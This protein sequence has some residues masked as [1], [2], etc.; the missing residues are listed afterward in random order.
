[1]RSAKHLKSILAGICAAA[2]FISAI[3]S[4]SIKAD[5]PSD[6]ST[7]VIENEK[8]S[9][10]FDAKMTANDDR[11]AGKTNI[12]VETFYLG[13]SFATSQWYS[14]DDVNS[15]NN[16]K[17]SAEAKDGYEIQQINY[18]S[19]QNGQNVSYKVECDKNTK[20]Y[21]PYYISDGSHIEV[22]VGDKTPVIDPA[23]DGYQ[24]FRADL[25]DYNTSAI[26]QIDDS[27]AGAKDNGLKFWRGGTSGVWYNNYSGNRVNGAGNY[28]SQGIVAATRKNGEPKFNVGTVPSIFTVGSDSYNGVT[29]KQSYGGVTFPFKY[30]KTSGMYSFDSDN[31]YASFD[32]TKVNVTDGNN[33]DVKFS[34]FNNDTYRN[35]TLWQRVNQNW[36]EFNNYDSKFS[37]GMKFG[38][39]FSLPKYGTVDGTE[40]GKPIVFDF[41]GDDDVWV[42]IDDQLVLDLGGIHGEAK[43]N[44]NF[45]TG[46]SYVQ[47]TIDQNN[48]CNENVYTDFYKEGFD[49]STLAGKEHT[50]TVY[51]FE[52]G[53]GQSNCKI[54]FNLPVI[55]KEDTPT[56]VSFRKVDTADTTKA[57]AGAK[58]TL[59]ST[60]GTVVAVGADGNAE[61]TSDASGMVNFK[62]VVQGTYTLTETKA[63]DGYDIPNPNTW[64]VIVTPDGKG[65]SSY[66]ITQT[67]F[68]NGSYVIK[69]TKQEVVPT[70][71]KTAEVT[72]YNNRTYKLTLNASAPVDKTT[73]VTGTNADVALIIDNSG[74]M[75]YTDA[76]IV[77]ETDSQGAFGKL[78]NLDTGKIYFTG[79]ISGYDGTKIDNEN[80]QDR[81]MSTARYDNTYYN[82][83]KG[84]KY[85]F[86][87]GDSWY[88][89]PISDINKSYAL[90]PNDKQEKIEDE[91]EYIKNKHGEYWCHE[92]RG[93]LT[94]K[95]YGE[96]YDTDKRKKDYG[97][98]FYDKVTGPY[99]KI[100]HYH[101]NTIYSAATKLGAGTCPNEIYTNRSEV[102]RNAV[103]S[104][105]GGLSDD[106][107]VCITTFNNIGNTTSTGFTKPSTIDTS[108]IAGQ[109]YTGTYTS[110]GLLKATDELNRLSKSPNKKYAIL[111]TD[112]ETNSTDVSTYATYL[113]DAASGGVYAIGTGVTTDVLKKVATADNDGNTDKYVKS[114]SDVTGLAKALEDIKTEITT[115]GSSGT[116]VD[117][118]DPR[119]ELI[120]DNGTPLADG[121]S[122]SGG[123]VSLA[124]GAYSIKWDG[125]IIGDGSDGFPVWTKTINVKAKSDFR[126]GNK[127]PT[128]GPESG[129]TIGD[130]KVKFPQPTVNVKSLDVSMNSG[131]KTL[132]K[133]EMIDTPSYIKELTE[134]DLKWN[135]QN[136]GSYSI[137]VPYIDST[138]DS[139]GQDV[140]KLTLAGT[141]SNASH[142]AIKTSEKNSD[143]SLK[144]V[145]TYTVTKTYVPYSIDERNNQQNSKVRELNNPAENCGAVADNTEANGTYKVYVVAGQVTITK[146]ISS[147]LTDEEVKQGDPIFTFKVVNTS[148]GKTEYRT[149]RFAEVNKTT[150]SA[151]IDDLDQ[152]IYEITELGTMRFKIDSKTIDTN[153]DSSKIANG[154]K[155][156]IG[157]TDLDKSKEEVNGLKYYEHDNAAV[158]FTNKKTD[159][160]NFSDTDVVK[161]SYSV[162]ADG[163][164]HSSAEVQSR[165][166]GAKPGKTTFN[167]PGK[168]KPVTVDQA[169]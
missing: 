129:V 65:G 50:L 78:S 36:N 3:P 87:A 138:G 84:E 167:V 125:Q 153:C 71:D 25:F 158:T 107:R 147:G 127:I 156:A 27:I 70:V 67:D 22:Y 68:S 110:E 106:S 28:A 136:D 162:G 38:T 151:T 44:I 16:S 39:S 155:V 149:A 40:N 98:L 123:T 5:A 21:A 124:N 117:D 96:E 74:S 29:Y 12:Y 20:K 109:Y 2:L 51:Y 145:E 85:L 139:I 93:N 166:G 131:E 150:W 6:A 48:N 15:G 52:R 11:V 94:N 32:G 69:N 154:Y 56:D 159:N 82:I 141:T 13:T 88:M 58:F 128:N 62:D 14:F 133:G 122:Y 83:P 152:G 7:T 163:K 103:K 47:G 26:N 92:K 119:F 102:V 34:P 120:D 144:P 108:V 24:N 160:D 9:L 61:Q 130:K 76:K 100:E 55:N 168:D 63:P 137:A 59:N 80:V 54:N 10:T 19:E 113:K 86:Y 45:K 33:S 165:V 148:T 42:F 104:F 161:N 90:D 132:F 66:I 134:K 75:I 79:S 111:F 135:K 30:D 53:A 37:F 73:T 142:K 126:G 97:E 91:P 95:K 143:G 18:V 140:Y 23:A 81:L 17:F 57:L 77:S 64:N 169:N 101:Y 43:G 157:Y 112:G 35:N 49:L 89:R 41:S 60:D 114:L 99:K 115:T 31:Q 146:N 121:A 118:V 1:M 105:M 4:T 72:D 164:I 116:V 46:K 8:A